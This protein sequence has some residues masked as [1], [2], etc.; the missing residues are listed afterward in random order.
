[1]LSHCVT[2]VNVTC[3]IFAYVLGTEVR[4]VRGV[5]DNNEKQVR[6][7]ILDDN[8]RISITMPYFATD[9]H[10]DERLYVGPC[11]FSINIFG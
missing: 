5:R 2:F 8:P 1:M 7:I 4:Q 10:G 9:M 11:R 3:V 6:K